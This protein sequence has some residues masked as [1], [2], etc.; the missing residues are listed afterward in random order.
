MADRDWDYFKS[1]IN[2][3]ETGGRNFQPNQSHGTSRRPRN[4]AVGNYGMTPIAIEQ[5]KLQTPPLGDYSNQDIIADNSLYNKASESYADFNNL[6]ANKL[7]LLEEDIASPTMMWKTGPGRFKQLMA[8]KPMNRN[9]STRA[10]NIAQYLRNTP[11]SDGS[12]RDA[13]K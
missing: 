8:G 6:E 3:L 12:W 13:L 11:K 1:L 2:N 5:A 4:V 10:R 9:E 7:G